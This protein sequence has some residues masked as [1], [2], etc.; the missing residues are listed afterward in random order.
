[1][2]QGIDYNSS[3]LKRYP[4][5]IAVQLFVNYRDLLVLAALW[6]FGGLT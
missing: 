5:S 1:M 2:Y 3:K 6:R 4:C